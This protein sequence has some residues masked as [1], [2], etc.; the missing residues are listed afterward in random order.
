MGTEGTGRKA[1]SRLKKRSNPGLDEEGRPGSAST[2]ET[3]THPAG[4]QPRPEAPGSRANAETQY[5]GKHK[6]L[7]DPLLQ[8]PVYEHRRPGLHAAGANCGHF[9]LAGK[10]AAAALPNAPEMERTRCPRHRKCPPTSLPTPT[11]SPARTPTP[12][13]ESSGSREDCT[14][15]KNGKTWQ[16]AR[17]SNPVLFRDCPT[18]TKRLGPFEDIQLYWFPTEQTDTDASQ[19][20]R[21][22]R[23]PQ[24]SSN[25]DVKRRLSGTCL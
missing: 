11:F 2:V 20:L 12:P 6:H 16:C 25:F 8:L 15:K 14:A 5:S 22:R 9:T 24:A 7:N 1:L 4:T 10:L 17:V 19:S 21:L 3:S 18:G 13:P 23:L